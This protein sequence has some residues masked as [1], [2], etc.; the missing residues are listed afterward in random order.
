MTSFKSVFDPK[1]KCSFVSGQQHQDRND[2]VSTNRSFLKSTLALIKCG[3]R[4]VP[5]SLSPAVVR[6]RFLSDH[7]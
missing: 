2:P 5:S 7:V 6:D 4:V 3:L 1:T